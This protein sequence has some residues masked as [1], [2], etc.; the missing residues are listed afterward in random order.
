MSC[1][2]LRLVHLEGDLLGVPAIFARAKATLVSV[3][4][5]TT[6]VTTAMRL[7]GKTLDKSKKGEIIAVR[8]TQL[9][10]APQYW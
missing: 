7:M 6:K 4:K 5:K 2:I 9:G 10:F 3:A 8:S 1:I